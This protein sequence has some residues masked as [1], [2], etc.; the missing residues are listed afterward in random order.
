[1]IQ[2]MN[3]TGERLSTAATVRVA[4]SPVRHPTDDSPKTADEAYVCFTDSYAQ[5]ERAP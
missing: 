2:Y 1:M 5:E 4:G 3:P